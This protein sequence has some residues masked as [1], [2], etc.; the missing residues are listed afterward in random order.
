VVR[1][2]THIDVL[3]ADPNTIY[4]ELQQIGGVSKHQCEFAG[5]DHG[6]DEQ[7]IQK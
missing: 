1:I 2:T 6:F 4:F 5:L 3:H 7:P